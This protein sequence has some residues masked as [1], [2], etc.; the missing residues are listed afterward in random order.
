MGE[1]GLRRVTPPLP[2]VPRTLSQ[3]V[4]EALR[5]E[6]MGGQFPPGAFLREID[7]GLHLGVSRTPIREALARLASEGF[8]DR[9][10]HRGFRVPTEPLSLLL[11]LYPVV[12]ALEVLAGRLAFPHFSETDIE[13]LAALNERMRRAMAEGDTPGEVEANR[14]FHQRIAT[15]S[16][17]ESLSALLE[18]LHSRIRRLET[19][20]YSVPEL[21][22]ESFEEHDAIIAELRRGDHARAVDLLGGNMQRTVGAFRSFSAAS[23]QR[24]S[25]GVGDGGAAG[26]GPG[27]A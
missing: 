2:I 22:R 13:E 21:G 10:P 6:L 16:R 9:L 24:P 11:E 19:W 8:L 4:Y 5:T 26:P 27:T 18:Q 17:N 1:P 3:Q 12:G 23:L 15:A 14:S 7:L 25:G 20:Y